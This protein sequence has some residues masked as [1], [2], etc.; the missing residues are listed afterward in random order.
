MAALHIQIFYDP[1]CFN[2]FVFFSNQEKMFFDQ[3]EK[4]FKI[5]A[6]Q[7]LRQKLI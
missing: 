5:D 6:K 4:Y 3:I 7:T 2:I 1:I